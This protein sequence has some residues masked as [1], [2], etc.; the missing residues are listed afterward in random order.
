MKEQLKVGNG[1]DS[2]ANIGP[3]INENAISKVVFLPLYSTIHF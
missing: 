1:F 3:L 2:S